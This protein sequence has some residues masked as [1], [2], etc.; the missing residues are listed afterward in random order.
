MVVVVAYVVLACWF[1]GDTCVA[2][3]APSVEGAY[4]SVRRLGKGWDGMGLD[5][6]TIMH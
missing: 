4:G 2:Q 1:A 3:S 6:A 5:M